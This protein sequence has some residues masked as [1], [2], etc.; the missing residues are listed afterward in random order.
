[1]RAFPDSQPLTDE[2]KQK[3]CEMLY[4][5][6]LEIRV[7]GWVDKAQQAADLADAFHN[8]PIGL[9]HDTF[10]FDFFRED[11]R[12]YCQKYACSFNY[13]AAVDEIRKLTG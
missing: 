11:L 5:A 3:L 13:L 8:L 7:A 1:M 10:S 6:L 2:Q 4:T 9:W 12:A